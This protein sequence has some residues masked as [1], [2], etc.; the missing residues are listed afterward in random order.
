VAAG[1]AAGDSSLT[2]EDTDMTFLLLVLDF[3]A[4]KIAINHNQTRIGD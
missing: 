3:V 2:R 4:G 1:A